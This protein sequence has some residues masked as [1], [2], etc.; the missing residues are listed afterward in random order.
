MSLQELLFF[1]QE[2]GIVRQLSAV[3]IRR[4][5]GQ[6]KKF[7]ELIVLIARLRP[8]AP[9]RAVFTTWCCFLQASTRSHVGII[10][11]F[12]AGTDRPAFDR[13]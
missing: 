9:E 6:I 3:A 7:L 5:E 1:P 2:F 8:A 11:G 10:S 13:L 12:G 4:S